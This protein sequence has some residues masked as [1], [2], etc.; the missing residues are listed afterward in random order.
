ML[1]RLMSAIRNPADENV[2]G[3]WT[4]GARWMAAL[5]PLVL[6]FSLSATH[7]WV[8]LRGQ[9]VIGGS[10]PVD[11]MPTMGPL[12][13]ICLGT[14]VLTIGALAAVVLGPLAGQPLPLWGHTWTP[15][16]C[17]SILATLMIAGDDVPHLVSPFMDQL[18]GS[19]VVLL[20]GLSIAAAGWR[21]PLLGGLASLSA[22]IP[23]SLL[24]V[25]GVSALPFRRLDIA[26]L[27]TVVGLLLGALIAAYARVSPRWR[28]PVLV[29][30][31]SLAL[32]VIVAMERGMFWPWRVSH[33]QIMLVWVVPTVAMATL[34]FGPAIGLI[35]RRV[36]PQHS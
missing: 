5:P 32:V 16:A 27:S 6:G 36:R 21:S 1:D 34:V 22:T 18:I 3:S 28:W 10:T 20:L 29:V 24:L 14:T 31:A 19:L 4:E 15:S 26:L 7:F 11:A 25:F 2:G 30:G 33:G 12:V 13:V 23:L 35:G 17:M 9:L 8:L